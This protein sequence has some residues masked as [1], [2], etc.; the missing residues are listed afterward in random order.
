MAGKLSFSHV[1]LTVG[2][3]LMATFV[4]T[5]FK[6]RF[7]EKEQKDEYHMVKEYLLN[8]NVLY[9][10]NR[11]KI[12]IHS[13]Y[14]VNA[15]K[16]ASFMSRTS[17]DLNQPYLYLTVQSIIQ[18]NGDDFHIC[19]IDDE[20]FAKLIPSWTIDLST[21][22]EPMRSRY[23]ENAMLQLLYIYGG[24]VVPNSFLCLQSLHGLYL[25]GIAHKTPFMAERIARIP[26]APQSKPF[27]PDVYFMGA[28][29]EDPMLEKLI[30]LYQ[31]LEEKQ[32]FQSETEF[33]YTVGQWC[34]YEVDAGNIQVV[35][36]T[37]IGIKTS[38]GKPVLLEDLMSED[39]LDIELSVLQG[40][41]IPSKELLRRP[42]Y[43]YFS[44]LPVEE[45][46]KTNS[47]LTKYF[48]IAMVDTNIYNKGGIRKPSSNIVAI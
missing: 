1:A 4:G 42:K 17:T 46:L 40:V 39:Y 38:I 20:S 6:Q 14:E 16:W 11:P 18:H 33:N 23:R 9:G 13:Q 37:L 44:I 5:S 45:V 27:L 8:P 26:N 7:S 43:Q 30:G 25:Q 2:L 31:S 28:T 34:K 41:Y 21:V 15:R 3:V 48:Q 12:W 10:K 47:V 29:K 35:D 36:G 19:L 24:M 22:P 32:H